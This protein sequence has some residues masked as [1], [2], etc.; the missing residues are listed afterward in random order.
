MIR[1]LAPFTATLGDAAQ[2]IGAENTDHPELIFSGIA[3]RD[4]DVEPGDL[5]LAIPG[6]TVHGATYS[7]KAN[8]RGAVAVITDS[9]GAALNS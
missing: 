5:F 1:P 6:A 8:T 7:E 3:I 4:S 9:T 2:L